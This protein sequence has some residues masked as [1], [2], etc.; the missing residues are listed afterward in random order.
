MASQL[1]ACILNIVSAIR[2]SQNTA[3]TAEDRSHGEKLEYGALIQQ[4][5]GFYIMFTII[6]IAATYG[7]NDIMQT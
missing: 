3:I 6:Y 2:H 4:V 7:D 1:V 5:L